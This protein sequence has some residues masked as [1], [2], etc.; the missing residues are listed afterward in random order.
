MN[1]KIIL[2]LLLVFLCGKY[3]SSQSILKI[4]IVSDDGN[5]VRYAAVELNDQGSLRKTKSELNGKA[6]LQWS[7]GFPS[8]LTITHPGF[9]VYGEELTK[10]DLR[11]EVKDTILFK[12]VMKIRELRPAVVHAV[13][14][15]DTVFGSAEIYIDD[16]NPS[17]SGLLLLGYQKQVNRDYRI[18][19]T[20]AG[21]KVF[22]AHNVYGTNPRIYSDWR[23]REWLLTDEEVYLAHSDSLNRVVPVSVDGQLFYNQ[24]YP[25]V[26]SLQGGF[27]FSNY[28]ENYPGFGY[29][30]Y[31]SKDSATHR[32]CTVEDKDMMELYLAEY[33]YASGQD[34]LWAYRQEQQTGI[35]KEVWI[36]AAKFTESLYY[37]P[38]YAPVFVVRDT[39]YLFDHYRDLLRSYT[40]FGLPIDS[41]PLVHHKLSKPYKWQ[42]Q[43]L[44]DTKTGELYSIAMEGNKSV[45][46]KIDCKTGGVIN[47]QKLYFSYPENIKVHNGL[48]Y[49]LYRPFESLQKRFLYSEKISAN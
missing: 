43:V 30:L 17:D 12:I 22:T 31:N 13:Q 5:P 37:K 44:Q 19:R 36:G 39:I 10:K 15:P 6:F 11:R 45:L 41:V 21:G 32:I 1:G 46:M 16:Y 24:V 47:S 26:D 8:V 2:M 18:Y 20:G 33:K 7:G 35:A 9:A 40:S 25:V 27:L 48:V 3:V 4:L 23:R 42:K 28:S 29:F 14:R 38:M 49:Y 34:K